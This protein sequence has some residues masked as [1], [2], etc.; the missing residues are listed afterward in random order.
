[1]DYPLETISDEAFRPFGALLRFR[2]GAGFQPAGHVFDADPGT[3]PDAFVVRIGQPVSLPLRVEEMERHPFSAQTFIPLAGG[4]AAVVVCP[5]AADGA[6]DFAG[7]RAFRLPASTGI[8]YSRGV[9]HHSV[10]AL[11]PSELVVL[12][13]RAPQGGDTEIARLPRA[14]TVGAK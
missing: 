13:A 8:T 6:P 11:E 4:G 12:M 2:G 7:L 3:R 14:V 5:A 9:W 10:C 1:M